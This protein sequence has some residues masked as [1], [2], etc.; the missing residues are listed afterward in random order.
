MLPVVQEWP[1]QM[2]DVQKDPDRIAK[3]PWLLPRLRP[4]EPITVRHEK[5]LVLVGAA[6]VIATYDLSLYSLAV[7]KIQQDLG[8]QEQ[9]VGAFNAL[10]RLAIIPA[11]VL[12]YLSDI[13]G[14]R[15]LLMATLAGAALGTVLAGIAQNVSEFVIAQV[16]ARMCIYTEEML[17][18][19]IV[20]EEFSERTRGW[21]VG[22]LGAFGAVGGGLAAIMYGMVNF[23]PYGWRFIY[24]VTAIPLIWLIWARSRLPETARFRD[25]QDAAKADPWRWF[26]PAIGLATQYPGRMALLIMTVAPFAFGMASAVFF[27]PKF[28]QDAHGWQP[29]NVTLLTISGG[30]FVLFGAFAAGALSDLIGRRT[31]LAGACLITVASFM[32]FYTI[33]EGWVALALCWTAGYFTVIIADVLF[34]ALG[35]E[36]FPTSYRAVASGLREMFRVLVGAAGLVL[37]GQLFLQTGDHG[38]AIAWLMLI[39]PLA[40]IPIFFLP[41]TA[42]R[43]LESIA[44]EKSADKKG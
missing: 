3:L 15:F 4:P 9:D 42:A 25:R 36:L 35:A 7:V 5:L 34:Q 13:I 8:I 40:I 12:S 24:V 30:I 23:L 39:S 26:R 44:P 20:A 16:I 27:F 11:L 29:W 21:A 10:F 32:A 22:A 2:T 28:L 38:V 14:R 31:V 33:A 19:V 17:V 18:V 43:S 1:P 41:E 6:S 37:E